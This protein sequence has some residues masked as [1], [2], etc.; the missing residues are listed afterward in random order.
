MAFSQNLEGGGG[1]GGAHCKMCPHL[2][3]WKLESGSRR[4]VLVSGVDDASSVVADNRKRRPGNP[5]FCNASPEVLNVRGMKHGLGSIMW[6]GER[7]RVLV[8]PVGARVNVRS[9]KLGFLRE[10]TKRCLRKFGYIYGWMR[11]SASF[12]HA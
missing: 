10:P 5:P 9:F 11:I 6:T 12:E 3:R 1:S 4:R 2:W 8:A 7:L